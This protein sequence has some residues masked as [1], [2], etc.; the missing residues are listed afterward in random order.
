[1]MFLSSDMFDIWHPYWNWECYQLGMW[2]GETPRKD[3]VKMSAKLL[4]DS[5]SLFNFMVRAIDEMPNSAQHN[6][7]KPYLN[8]APWLGQSACF[9]YCGATEEETR[10]AWCQKLT[11][12]EQV[13]ANNSAKRACDYWERKYA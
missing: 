11:Y 2:S 1:M 4:K 3:V 6:L 12:E 13:M 7:S 5:E 10:L 8:R 9:L